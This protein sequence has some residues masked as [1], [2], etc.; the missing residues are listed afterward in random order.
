MNMFTNG[1]GGFKFASKSAIEEFITLIKKSF[2]T[3][4]KCVPCKVI[5]LNDNALEPVYMTDGAACADVAIPCDITINPGQCAVVPLGLG[6]DIP[7]FFKIVMYPRSS[8][9]TKYGIMQPT[10][11]IDHDY[12]G[13]EVHAPLFNATNSVIVLQKGTRVAQIECVPVYDCTSWP[14]KLVE[15]TGGFGSTGKGAEHE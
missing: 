7:L 4:N 14:R 1:K 13:K 9:L 8:L 10:S 12:S 3:S 15:R 11:I 2:T 5:K 6:F